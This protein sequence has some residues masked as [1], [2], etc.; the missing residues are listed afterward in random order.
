M[1]KYPYSSPVL[2]E[3]KYFLPENLPWHYLPVWIGI[4][5]PVIV[6]AGILACMI[7]W[8][9]SISSFIRFKEKRAGTKE[10]CFR[11]SHLVCGN[12]LV[13]DPDCRNLPYSIPSLRW[14]AADVFYLSGNCADQPAGLIYLYHWILRIPL[15]LNA[16]RIIAGIVLLGGLIEPVWFMVRYHPFE[17][18]YFN[19]FAGDPNTLRQPF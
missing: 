4:T 15:R 1:S 8:I 16:I 3:G 6:L 11:D 7:G 19:V 12:R 13:G 18:V 5:T 17:N 10:N 14:L 2:Y 9:G